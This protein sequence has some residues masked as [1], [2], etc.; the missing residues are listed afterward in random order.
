MEEMQLANAAKILNEKQQEITGMET[1]VNQK[2]E[3]L[4]M[5]KSLFHS[6]VQK[7]AGELFDVQG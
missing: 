3:T 5:Q 1:L 7:G 2:V 6:E 4:G